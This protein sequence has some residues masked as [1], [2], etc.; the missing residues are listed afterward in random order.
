MAL[1]KILIIFIVIMSV[2]FS[3]N[4]GLIGKSIK[5][6]ATYTFVRFAVPAITKGTGKKAAG[7][8]LKKLK[9]KSFTHF[10]ESMAVLTLIAETN[11]KYKD[12]VKEIMSIA[13]VLTD[14]INFKIEENSK[15]FEEAKD[16]FIEKA[17]E[18]DKKYKKRSCDSYKY[19]MTENGYPSNPNYIHN[20]VREW[21]VA[22]YGELV[23]N[24]K[25]HDN[26]EHDHI[27]SKQAIKNFLKKKG[28]KISGNYEENVDDNST[29]IEVSRVNHIKGATFGGKQNSKINGIAKK[30]FDA[31]DLRV[32]TI[33]DM[34]Y[35]FINSKDSKVIK[36]FLPLYKRN[37]ELCLYN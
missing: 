28:Y 35:H 3:S 37:L 24:E 36:S 16:I 9:R 7:W 27:P 14:E 26:L 1:K 33:R 11:V 18:L 21:D 12:N 2:S 20:P 23:D 10:T 5:V 15:E 4:A 30:F 31:E 6:G 25:K 13:G 22:A 29:A 34:S 32:A 19:L 8:A 17:N